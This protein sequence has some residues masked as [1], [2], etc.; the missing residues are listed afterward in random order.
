MMN[1]ASCLTLLCNVGLVWNTAAIMKIVTQL[2]AACD[3][4]PD[5]DLPR[6]SPLM[7]QQVTPTER[8]ILLVRTGN[9]IA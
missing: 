6:I 9:E 1:K 7:H 2:R 4:I 5:E 3:A 8:I